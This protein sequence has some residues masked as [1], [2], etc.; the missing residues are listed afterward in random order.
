MVTNSIT[1]KLPNPR[2]LQSVTP[3]PLSLVKL[4]TQ[5]HY[6]NPFPFQVRRLPRNPEER[7]QRLMCILKEAQRLCESKDMGGISHYAEISSSGENQDT[8]TETN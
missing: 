8:T 4:I 6:S 5:H 1:S 2:D 3:N 7:Q